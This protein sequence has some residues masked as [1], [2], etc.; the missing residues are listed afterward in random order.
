MQKK[1]LL[2][3]FLDLLMLSTLACGSSTFSPKS[4]AR[5]IYKRYFEES[6]LKCGES[7]VFYFR[8]L[9]IE[10]YAE[11]RDFEILV[12]ST[13]LTQADRANGI[14]WKGR[15]QLKPAMF[16]LCGTEEW[17]SPE[18]ITS[19]TPWMM[20]ANGSSVATDL[21]LL[22]RGNDWEAY[23]P[24]FM[25]EVTLRSEPVTFTCEVCE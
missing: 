16:R 20:V 12:E 13:E 15:V 9:M 3:G 18:D 23:E 22:K 1:T 8:G 19:P 14:S 25:Q 24:T 2:V 17:I 6:T 7:Q 21:Y 11:V 4:E 5:E 10:W